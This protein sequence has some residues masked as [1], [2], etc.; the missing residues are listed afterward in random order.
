LSAT[1]AELVAGLDA[2]VLGSGS[3]RVEDLA[4]DSRQ[5]RPG[6]LFAAL[7]GA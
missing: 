7:R 2:R 6:A 1:L 3:V 5:V 4:Y